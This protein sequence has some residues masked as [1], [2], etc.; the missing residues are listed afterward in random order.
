MMTSAA[1][2]QN[3]LLAAALRYAARGW[4]VF[5]C[6]WITDVR[7]VH[8]SCRNLACKSP[9]KHPL[10]EHGLSEATTD[11]EQIKA[12]WAQWPQAHVAIRTGATS[13]GHGLGVVDIDKKHNGDE[14]FAQLEGGYGKFPDGPM[15]YTM[16]G[17]RHF[18]G[19]TDGFLKST[20][21]IIGP[22]VDTRGDGGYVVAP[23]SWGYRWELAHD[24]GDPLPDMPVWVYRL[25]NRAEK[26]DRPKAEPA[27]DA[28][29]SG[30]RNDG[31]TKIAGALR[32]KG[33][34]GDEI[35]PALLAVND[36]R[37]TPPLDPAEVKQ[38]AYGMERYEA[39]DPIKPDN[40]PDS[41]AQQAANVITL[42]DIWQDLPPIQWVCERFGLTAGA[43]QLVAGYGYSGK[44][45][46]LQAMALAIVFGRNAWDIFQCAR[47]RVV[48]FDYDGQG[49]RL[50]TH[51]YQR[52]ARGMGFPEPTTDNDPDDLRAEIL[53]TTY[54]DSA[55][56]Y[57][58][59]ARAMDGRT[60]AIVDSLRAAAPTADENS[61]EIRRHIDPLTRAS[62]TTGC[63]ATLVHHARKPSEGAEGGK[64][65]IRGSG[66][67]FDGCGSVWVFEGPKGKPVRVSCEK[68]RNRGGDDRPFGLKFD[69]VG[70]P[71]LV[72]GARPLTPEQARWGI[73]V[74]HLEPEQMARQGASFER[75]CTSI[76]ETVKSRPSCSLRFIRG[77]V[78]GSND[79]KA[80]AIEALLADGTL[81][82]IPEGKGGSNVYR[83]V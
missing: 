17:G 38:I 53:P 6:T 78:Q 73:R 72:G 2:H 57:D 44:T 64:F 79:L 16:N 36:R 48:H 63:A 43:P 15:A 11:P 71:F 9:G 39:T 54:L 28:F 35:L 61:S 23:P 3:L 31:L 25:A 7:R 52:L 42:A 8:C 83:A 68:D 59:F 70:D 29:I 81:V 45:L 50:T 58:F 21:S 51:R 41:D 33:L 30:G 10:T 55:Q 40:S 20:V 18:Y 74:V 47:G 75:L 13:S 27:P 4:P 60:W 5:P 24:D 32:R 19:R 69:D 66:A 67:I 49:R 56:A 80:E 34:V 1:N 77:S 37:C 65:S 46:A 62:E 82:A 12:W 22:G 14:S 26:G 76:L